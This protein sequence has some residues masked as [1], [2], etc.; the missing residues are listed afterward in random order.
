MCM[1]QGGTEVCTC[2]WV[3]EELRYVYVCGSERNCGVYMC[4][5]QGG[6]E[7]CTCVWVKE[8]LRCV[9]VYGSGRK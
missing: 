5:G 9:H 4:M 1:G 8:E 3:R 2:V 7:V 6:S